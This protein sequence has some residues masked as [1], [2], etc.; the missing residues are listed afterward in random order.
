VIERKGD[1]E[2]WKTIVGIGVVV[3]IVGA[4]LAYSIARDLGAL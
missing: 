2:R 1:P 3:L 4:V